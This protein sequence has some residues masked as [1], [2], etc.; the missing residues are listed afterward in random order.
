MSHTPSWKT[1]LCNP[2]HFIAFGFGSG[3]APKAPGTFGTL[4]AI[5]IYFLL[6]PL[7]IANYV[8]VLVI[9]TLL[10][11]YIAGKSAQ[12]LGIHDHGGI[13]IDE[14]CGFLVTMILAPEG[15]E[16]VAAGFVLFRLFDIVKPW[17]IN[18]LDK[19]VT[20]GIGIV[21]DDLMAGI[22]ALLSLEL[23]VWLVN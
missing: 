5:P 2:V 20:G 15:W 6:Q 18:Y 17:P 12:L 16:W 22:Y 8:I 3:L 13:V 19:R 11:I 1:I 4:I 21:L 14:I 9:L 23:I 10:S 7:S